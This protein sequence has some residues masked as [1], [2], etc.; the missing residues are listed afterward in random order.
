[1]GWK[2]ILKGKRMSDRAKSLIDVVMG[3][4]KLTLDEVREKMMQS[5]ELFNMSTASIPTKGEMT[6]YLNQNYSSVRVRR[7]HPIKENMEYK[8]VYFKEE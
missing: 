6:R 3:S 1:M 7:R 5:L 4:E 8:K 2:N